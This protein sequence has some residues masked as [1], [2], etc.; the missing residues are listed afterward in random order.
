MNIKQTTDAIIAVGGWGFL[1]VP[2]AIVA[3]VIVG[4]IHE[5][6]NVRR[7]VT[8]KALDWAYATV[9]IVAAVALA[10]AW[11]VTLSAADAYRDW[12][13]A[14]SPKAPAASGAAVATGG[15]G[16]GSQTAAPNMKRAHRVEVLMVGQRADNTVALSALLTF[17]DGS[18]AKCDYAVQF[19]VGT[20]GKD[21]GRLS[22]SP[23]PETEQCSPVK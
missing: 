18:K 11:M 14:G 9:G 17:E 13:A 5:R 7:G 23:V 12:H 10:F 20:S 3:A 19:K 2:L 6:I 8:I 1:V 15:S 22:F 16:V 21:E 4:S